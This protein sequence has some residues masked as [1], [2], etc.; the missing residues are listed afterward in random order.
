M[1]L[2][3]PFLPQDDLEASP[4]PLHTRMLS[5]WSVR[6]ELSGCRKLQWLSNYVLGQNAASKKA[7]VLRQ[8]HGS[9]EYGIYVP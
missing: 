1:P 8:T 7:E 9:A 2:P 6:L 4:S 3:P 5:H